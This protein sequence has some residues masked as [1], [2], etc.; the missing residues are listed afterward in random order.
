MMEDEKTTPDTVCT[1]APVGVKR[2]SSR[3]KLTSANP[4]TTTRSDRSAAGD[5]FYTISAVVDQCLA[6]FRESICVGSE[7]LIIEPGAGAGAFVAG[8][9][10]MSNHQ[11]FYDISPESP[12]IEQQDYLE[13]DTAPLAAA[14]SRIHV[15]GNPPFGRQSSMAAKFIRKSC[16]FCDSV[17]FVLPRSFKKE[18][19]ARIFPPNFHLLCELDLPLTAFT[20]GGAPYKVPCVF[21]VWARRDAIREKSFPIE[22]RYF[23]FTTSIDP[24]K[25]IHAAVRRVGGR[26][27]EIF[28]GESAAG[29]CAASH[30]F[31]HFFSNPRLSDM[32]LCQSLEG[33]RFSHDNTVG[34]RSISKKELIVEFD[35]KIDNF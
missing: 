3:H 9:K 21:Q 31:L 22:S 26:A 16:G 32:S 28:W 14:Y 13:L 27:G 19:M 7:D 30:Y 1:E 20:M 15:V 24:P 11:K 4:S 2:H 8:I 17:G 10:A 5:K 33:V 6:L 29:R 35:A 18:S 12:D 34:P 25:K 23:A